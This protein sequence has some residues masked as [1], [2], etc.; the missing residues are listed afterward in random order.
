MR[1]PLSAAGELG[2]RSPSTLTLNHFRLQSLKVEIW[3]GLVELHSFRSVIVGPD[4]SQVR[5]LSRRRA[6]QRAR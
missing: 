1:E 2:G 3:L 5:A 6:T 4:M